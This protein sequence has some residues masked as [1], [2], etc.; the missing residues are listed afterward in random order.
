[1]DT[2][3][4][5]IAGASAN[6]TTDSERTIFN[7]SGKQTSHVWSIFGFY[8]R[9]GKLDKSYAI[10]KLCRAALK[11]TGSTT[12]L[13]NHA[14]RKHRD[15]Y[16]ELK[17]RNKQQHSNDAPQVTGSIQRY[18]GKLG[19]NSTRAKEI[20]NAI[21]RFIAKGL[22][23]YSVVECDGFQ[24]LLHT[25]EPRYTLPTRKHFSNTC[26]PA[27]YAQVKSQVEEE[28][29][30][31]ERVALTTDAWTS[32]ATESYIT[33][34]AHHINSDWQLKCHVLQ[35]RVFKGSHTGKNIGA[36]LKQACTDWNLVDKHPAL[37]T[38]NASNMVLAGE[39]A[40]MS[41]HLMC[42]AHTINLASQKAFKVNTVARLLGRVR[43]VVSFFH[44]SVRAVNILQEKQ[45]QLALPHHK[46]IQDVSTRWN[47]SY[48]MLERF[49]E[50]QPA[51]SAALLSRDIRNG[52]VNT[53]KAED[54]CD[55]ED[56]VKLMAPVKLVTT[57][58][59]EDKQPTLSVISPVKAKLK[60]TFETTDNDTV[61]LR[62]M[63]QAFMNDMEKRYSGLDH[64]FHTAAALD[65]RF[66]SLPFL[67]DSDAERIFTSISEEATSLHEKATAQPA[68]KVTVQTDPCQTD[69]AHE[70]PDITTDGP[71]SNDVP[72]TDYG[73]PSKKK[74]KSA[75]DQLLGEDFKVKTPVR[76]V[77]DKTSE[78]VR[79]YRDRESLPLKNN[80][81]QWWQEQQDL[82]MLSSLAK[83]GPILLCTA[84]S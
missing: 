11:Y 21:T 37:I 7:A 80:P 27:L 51:I 45:K 48:D 72:P 54:F 39:E 61:V 58:M 3:T 31:A 25:L 63:K 84:T 64:L 10:C 53:L 41:P 15:E 59:S 81:L 32:C 50:Q 23:P 22:C 76:A 2:S 1:M 34:T 26:I 57:T 4:A 60:K 71:Q 82:P 67:K 12:N 20:T 6:L 55:A 49:L 46:L 38:D 75:L 65:P 69:P 28:L 70:V 29:A 35:T 40:E 13:D 52:D 24:D 77:I 78:E 30:R 5:A 33:I 42:F 36:L 44:R 62:E 18:F 9:G 8:K 73:P 47:S 17:S 56:I 16:G 66:K 43:R 68:E 14:T 19:Y 74:K 83:R 79:R